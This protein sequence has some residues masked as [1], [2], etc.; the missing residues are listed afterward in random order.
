MILVYLVVA[1]YVVWI[2][3]VLIYSLQYV[4]FGLDDQLTLSLD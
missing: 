1:T 4:C 3:F 2:S